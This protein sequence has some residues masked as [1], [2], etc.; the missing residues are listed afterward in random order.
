MAWTFLNFLAYYGRINQLIH[1]LHLNVLMDSFG[2]FGVVL[3]VAL[4]TWTSYKE[5][6]V[7][8]SNYKLLAPLDLEA[9][10]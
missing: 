5:A 6:D 8:L 1:Y 7:F 2:H 4:M 3:V 9:G 10:K